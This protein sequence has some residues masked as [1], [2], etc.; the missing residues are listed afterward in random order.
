M[1]HLCNQQLRLARIPDPDGDLADW[2]PFAHTI[3]GYA[4]AGGFDA[5]AALAHNDSATTLTELRAALFFVARADRHSGGSS[6]V[7]PQVRNLLRRI[8]ARVAAGELA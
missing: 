7:R 4:A 8:R 5:C 3:D 2:G 6:D 1:T